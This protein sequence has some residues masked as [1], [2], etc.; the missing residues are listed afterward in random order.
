MTAASAF[1][2]LEEVLSSLLGPEGC[3]WDKEQTPQSLCEYLAEE[4]FELID[5]VRRGNVADIRDEMGDVL[6]LLLF[7]SRLHGDTL[8]LAGVFEGAATKLVRRHPH[9]FADGICSTR[10]ELLRVWEKIKSEEKAE[11]GTK[12]KGVFSG[13][14]DGLPPMLKAYRIHAKAAL[15]GFTWDADADVEQQVEAEWLEWL[16]ACQSN[17]VLRQEHEFGDLLFSLV[18]LGRRKGI[19][20][21]AA[22]HEAL[23]RFLR[24]FAYMEAK[25][26]SLGNDIASLDMEVKNILWEEAKAMENK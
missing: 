26:A 4:T 14:P 23:L 16:D 22:L 2:V 21:N 1:V 5:A 8:S 18:E 10:D 13:L 20:A 11:K 7:I 9:V 17:D 15:A 3:P 6:F 19:K 24:R 25:A 12:R